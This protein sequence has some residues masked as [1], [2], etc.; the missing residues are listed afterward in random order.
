MNIDKFPIYIM[1]DQ[2]TSCPKC[3]SRADIIKEFVLN[4]FIHNY[5]IVV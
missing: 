3:Q 2:P 4:N 5:A 1:T